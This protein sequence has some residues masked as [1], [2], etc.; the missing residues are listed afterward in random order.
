MF[1][2]LVA[3]LMGNSDDNADSRIY[4]DNYQRL[5]LSLFIVIF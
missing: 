1:D 2:A 5:H 4:H 3:L